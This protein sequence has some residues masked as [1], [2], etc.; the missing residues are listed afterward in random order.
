MKIWESWRRNGTL[1][2]YHSHP[3]GGT[4][5]SDIDKWV[6]HRS[7]EDVIHLI[8]ATRRDEFTAY[9]AKDISIVTLMIK[10]VEESTQQD[11]GSTVTNG[12]T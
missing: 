7:G 10:E 3:I 12:P 4:Y 9:R 11:H 6:M 2:V 5:P 1:I 8:Y